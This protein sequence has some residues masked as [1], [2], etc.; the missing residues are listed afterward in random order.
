MNASVPLLLTVGDVPSVPVVPP[1]PICKVP[2]LMV[3]EPLQSLLAVSVVVPVP[4][5]VT[6]PVPEILAL[7]TKALSLRL[8]TRAPLSVMA[9][10]PMVPDVPP[11]PICKVPALMVVV[12]A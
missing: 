7:T 8:K 1:L 9:P 6:V 4:A 5:W 11:L 10:V 3:V 2:A 12:P